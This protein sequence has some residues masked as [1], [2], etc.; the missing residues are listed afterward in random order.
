VLQ[1]SPTLPPNLPEMIL[2]VPPLD[3]SPQN[4]AGMTLITLLF[5]PQLG[6]QFVLGNEQTQGQVWAFMP[7]A[8]GNALGITSESQYLRCILPPFTNS[9]F[10]G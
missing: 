1:S 4:L 9:L 5:E 3:T 2:P 10:S 8:I 6:Y 7:Q